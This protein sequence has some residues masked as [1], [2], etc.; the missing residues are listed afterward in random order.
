[1]YLPACLIN[2]IGVNGVVSRRQARMKALLRRASGKL[3][4]CCG[5]KLKLIPLGSLKL[6]NFCEG[7]GVQSNFKSD[8]QQVAKASPKAIPLNQHS[9]QRL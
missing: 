7:S 4:P 6:K 8:N 3:V 5:L 1:M 9:R 2:Q